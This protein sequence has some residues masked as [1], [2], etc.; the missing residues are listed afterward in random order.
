[1]KH[2]KNWTQHRKN[3]DDYWKAYREHRA[4][5]IEEEV[6]D[7]LIEQIPAPTKKEEE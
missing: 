5:V 6:K 2:S 7:L 4:K 3:L 1:M